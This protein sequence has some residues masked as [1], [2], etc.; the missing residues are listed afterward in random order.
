MRNGEFSRED[1]T[2]RL[3]TADKLAQQLLSEIS[4]NIEVLEDEKRNDAVVEAYLKVLDIVISD[5]NEDMTNDFH[6]S[7]YFFKRAVYA[8][9]KMKNLLKAENRNTITSK[10]FKHFTDAIVVTIDSAIERGIKK[11]KAAYVNKRDELITSVKN[12]FSRN[13]IGIKD[14]GCYIATAVYGSYDCP[15][16]WALRRYRDQSLNMTLFGR[17]LIRSYYAVSPALVRWFGGTKWIYRILR[18]LLN[19]LI[20][21][22]RSH[23]YADT[24]YSDF[25][26]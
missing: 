24:P 5:S 12:E 8:I 22:L 16:V 25:E 18:L 19:R 7:D 10:E 15:Q 23:G 1:Y 2:K 4:A 6:L 20:E 11:N 9:G 26:G 17:M 21:E 13:G 3:E 14:A